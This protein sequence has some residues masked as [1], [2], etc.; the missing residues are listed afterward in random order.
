[1][2]FSRSKAAASRDCISN[3]PAY[4][5]GRPAVVGWSGS[6]RVG[7]RSATQDSATVTASMDWTVDWRYL[8]TAGKLYAIHHKASLLVLNM[9]AM[10]ATTPVRIIV[11]GDSN[12]E[13]L[14]GVPSKAVPNH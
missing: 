13:H 6:H 3:A 8:I 5:S 10:S 11:L 1:M 14:T 7:R 9:F 4:E 12:Q 2:P